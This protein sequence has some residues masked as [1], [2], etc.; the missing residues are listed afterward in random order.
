MKQIV[1]IITLII[2]SLNSICQINH[3]ERFSIYDFLMHDTLCPDNQTYTCFPASLEATLS[4]PG[5][6]ALPTVSMNFLIPTSCIIDS[7]VI[8]EEDTINI[9]L[10]HK[11][12]PFQP[13][14]P[15]C[16]TCPPAGFRSMDSSI[17]F[18]NLVYPS[19]NNCSFSG[20]WHKARILTVQICPFRYYPLSNNLVLNNTMTINIYYTEKEGSEATQKVNMTNSFYSEFTTSLSK[21]V[22]NPSSIEEFVKGIEVVESKPKDIPNLPTYDY[23]IIAPS[24]FIITTPMNTFIEWKKKKGIDIGAIS[25]T[26]AYNYVDTNNI[27]TDNIG[28]DNTNYPNNQSIADNAAKLRMYLKAI[29]DSSGCR[30]I[31]LV[32]DQNRI[33][34][35][36]YYAHHN[37][38]AIPPVT[39]SYAIT[40]KYYADFNSDYAVDANND[41]GEITSISSPSIGDKVDWYPE[42]YIGRIPCSTVDQFGVWVDK[43]I[44]YETNPGNGDASYLKRFVITM[45]DEPQKYILNYFP[46]TL[47]NLSFFDKTEFKELPY[48]Y[49]S[50][51][52]SPYGQTIISSLNTS[53]AGWWTWD[54]HGDP[55]DFLTMTDS[56]HRSTISWINS[57]GSSY[58]LLNL[59]NLNKY[60]II[61]SNCC[62]VAN[63]EADDN[64]LDASIFNNQGGSVAFS[65]N[66]DVGWTLYGQ[67]KLSKLSSILNSCHQG[68]DQSLTRLCA[69]EWEW[70]K[71]KSSYVIYNYETYLTNNFFGDP[72]MMYY[73]KEPVRI[74]ADLS[75][76]HIDASVNNTYQ[77]TINNLPGGRHAIVCL[78]KPADGLQP[79]FQDTIDVTQV[80]HQCVATFNIPANTLSTGIMYVTATSFDM[81]PFMDEI[82][83]SPG[84]TKNNN[85]ETILVNTTYP[86][87]NPVFKD[88]D[89]I[90][91]AGATLTIYGEVYFVPNA[92]IIVEPG[93]RLV[94][95]GGTISASCEELW[96][97]I[98]VWGNA[99]LSQAPASNQ[100]WVKMINGALIEN[101]KIGVATYRKDGQIINYNYTGGIVQAYNTTF[102]NCSHGVM[103]YPY[104]NRNLFGSIYGNVSGFG[105]CTFEVNNNYTG[106]DTIKNIVSLDQVRG[107]DFG[108]CKFVNNYTSAIADSIT[109]IYSYNSGFGVYSLCNSNVIPCDDTTHSEFS[110]LKYGIKAISSG[111]L[112][113]IK[114]DDCL[115][116]DNLRSV[117]LSGITAPSVNRNLITTKVS[118]SQA[119]TSCGIYLNNCNGY[120]VQENKI[121]GHYPSGI[122]GNSYETGIVINNSGTDP[123]EIYNNTFTGLQNGITAQDDNRGLVCKCNDYKSVKTD[124]SVLITGGSSNTI[125][126]ALYQGDSLSITGLAGNTFSQRNQSS[127]TY[128]LYNQG[129][130]FKYYH[131]SNTPTKR[132]KPEY[133]NNNYAKEWNTYFYDK[134]TSCLS[135]LNSGGSDLEE[136]KVELQSTST[137]V[138]QKETELQALVDGGATEQTTE[139]IFYSIPPEA[140]ML[141]DELLTKSPYLSDTV[142]QS[143]AANE[144]VLPNVMIRDI[145]VANPQSASSEPVL[146]ELDK[147]IEPMPE[148]LYNQIL[149]AESAYSPFEIR[150]M[151][152]ASLKAK[153]SWLFNSIVAYY[154]SDTTGSLGDSLNVA[155]QNAPFPEGR[156][157]LALKQMTENDTMAATSTLQ[158]I[159]TSFELSSEQQATLT[160]YLNYFE[161]LKDINRDTLPGTKTDSTQ[162]AFLLALMEIVN[163]SVKSY[164]RNI[165]IANEVITYEEP[166]LFAD[167]LKASRIRKPNI[168]KNEEDAVLQI[169]PNPATGYFIVKYDLKNQIAPAA[170]EV[171]SIHGQVLL[172][173]LLNKNRDQ[174]VV[175]LIGFSP[176]IYIVSIRVR[177]QVLDNCRL[178]V[179]K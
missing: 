42:A 66:T 153:Q 178:I 174:F 55:Y 96:Q 137:S 80:N 107:V 98:E 166:Y 113:Y 52:T 103:F 133:F 179:V 141:R 160:D 147:R 32:G 23:V 125:G 116:S 165:L 164:I 45:A 105:N 173:K 79:E 43:I 27:S 127:G 134:Q 131:H 61:S 16:S 4:Q 136:M 142:M 159:S 65:G 78:Y 56:V 91:K 124:Q 33:P 68:G 7:I 47:T 46:S 94:V 25:L 143:A 175:P 63:F 83:I 72:D 88:R 38:D 129:A 135:K 119:N 74:D 59:S 11:I 84:C 92:R 100:G 163:E 108:A 90:V 154:L 156:Y 169:S 35:R 28:N 171:V 138:Q 9:T 155:L 146:N 75:S 1:F 117:Y 60:G 176:D 114:I 62:L 10:N 111:V 82:L 145:L 17:Y 95:D 87:G 144:F 158:D 81:M 13:P 122:L 40:D 31:L 132:L 172:K 69:A 15:S 152:L 20:F 34:V 53:P 109:G 8:S 14:A 157:L 170:I 121:T 130:R 85:A 102:R 126:I 5:Q 71:L 54:N 115:F 70:Y 149:D 67:S 51:P 150:E 161:I 118:T 101:A 57:S 12:F 26:D 39:P 140:L 24:A 3:S 106:T 49:S 151:E 58:G 112:K 44:N 128:D 76:R 37:P 41:W 99:T 123:N 73:T 77:V 120:S 30:Q 104:E 167:E 2:C 50:P 18:S 19:V 64:M 177:E 148:D 139:D 93:A 36:K 21:M 29:Y 162:T 89:V 110:G 168:T 48:Y 86:A 22:E 6:P 97:G